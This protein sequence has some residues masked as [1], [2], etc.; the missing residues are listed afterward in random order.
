MSFKNLDWYSKCKLIQ[1]LKHAFNL[2]ITLSWIFVSLYTSKHLS[3]S[4]HI[5]GKQFYIWV[6]SYTSSLYTISSIFCLCFLG[7]I[8]RKNKTLALFS[9]FSIISWCQNIFIYIVGCLHVKCLC[10]WWISNSLKHFCN[11]FLCINRINGIF[12]YFGRFCMVSN[13]WGFKCTSHWWFLS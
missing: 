10:N 4:N 11:F 7:K 2:T 3:K 12:K 13:R 6:I 8:N 5:L 1:N 9:S